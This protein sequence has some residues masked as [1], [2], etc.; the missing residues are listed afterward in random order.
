MAQSDPIA[1]L[2]SLQERTNKVFD[3]II[4]RHD[5]TEGNLALLVTRVEKL[6]ELG[7]VKKEESKLPV[8][9]AFISNPVVIMGALLVLAFLVIANVDLNILL[10][11]IIEKL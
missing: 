5:V 6:E 7:K 10:P 2:I 4:A 9:L 11:K 8:L 1:L 3:D